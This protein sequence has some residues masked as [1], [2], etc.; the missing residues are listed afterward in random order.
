[1]KQNSNIGSLRDEVPQSLNALLAVDIGNSTIGLGIFPDPARNTKLFIKKIPT[2]P[3]L[4]AEAYKKIIAEIIEHFTH[5][6]IHPF[7]HSPKIDSIISSV[8]PHIDRPIIEAAKEICGKK[9][10]VV[11]HKS[12]SGIAFE[13]SK[14]S[15]VGADR[16]ANAAA[17]FYYFK[18]PVAVVDFGTATTITVCAPATDETSILHSNTKGNENV[19]PAE[20]GIQRIREL[21]SRLHGND[22]LEV[23]S[24][25]KHRFIG[26]AI[27]PGMELML[28]S[29][30]SGTS[31]L[32][33]AVLKKP[34]TVLGKSTV[35][36]IISGIVHGTAGSVEHLI[37]S[38]EK[39]TGFELKLVLTGGHAKLMSPLIKRKHRLI[40]ELTFYGLRLIYLKAKSGKQ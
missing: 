4:S 14:P 20:A 9:P 36:S 32:P 12:V 26:G 19:I 1:M 22:G 27:M 18:K 30:Y 25:Q 8:V 31:K 7:T 28:K 2:H 17:G 23:F 16:I 38:M 21:D 29:L 37:K 39:E 5:S 33:L 40:P 15:G 34:D 10:L 24:Y 13:V 35:S 3:A 6:P 11:S